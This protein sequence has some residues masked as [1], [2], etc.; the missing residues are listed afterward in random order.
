MCSYST[1]GLLGVL[2]TGMAACG[3]SGL[4][5]PGDGAPPSLRAI[6][7]D[8]QQGT[9]GSRLPEPLVVRL[10]DGA[11][12]PLSGV[13]LRF[14]FQSEFPAATIDPATP[15]TNDS[16]FAS[17]EV[18]LG[19][20]E[21][22]QTVVARLDDNAS[23]DQVR[24]T[25]GVTAVGKKHGPGHEDEHGST[26]PGNGNGQGQHDDKHGHDDHGHDHG[27]EDEGD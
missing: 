26:P 22:P 14:E 23:S 17:V 9:V 27:H 15:A 4:T 21:G 2:M 19:S 16:G 5:L 11:A 8:G 18:R 13:A 12:H 6:S 24:A 25:F 10:T 1:V 20:A 3:G 7:G